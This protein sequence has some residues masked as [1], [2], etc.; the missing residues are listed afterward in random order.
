MYLHPSVLRQIALKD[1]K[2]AAKLASTS[3]GA[4]AA[5]QN[6][7]STAASKYRAAGRKWKLRSYQQS[8]EYALTLSVHALNMYDSEYLDSDGSPQIRQRAGLNRVK[9]ALRKEDVHVTKTDATSHV[10]NTM[11]W[12]TALSGRPQKF[13]IE[14]RRGEGHWRIEYTDKTRPVLVVDGGSGREVAGLVS[15]QWEKTF[16]PSSTYRRKRAELQ[17]MYGN[18]VPWN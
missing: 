18:I 2:A 13:V 17:Q 4:R 7:A 12:K 11:W 10:S 9:R 5:T 6:V 1:P 15:A 16:G 8:V 14:N 3:R